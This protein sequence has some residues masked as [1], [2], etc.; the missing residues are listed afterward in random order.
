MNALTQYIDLY[1]DNAEAIMKNS[2]LFSESRRKQACDFLSG[3]QMP[4]KGDEGFEKTSVEDMFAPDFGVNINRVNI[5]VDVAA[6][7]KC[8][9]PNIS[10]LLGIVV[11]DMFVPTAT[12]LKNCPQGV[13]VMS[14]AKAA[15]EFSEIVSKYLGSVAPQDNVNAEL[16]TML[17]QDGVFIRLEAG[18]KL[19]KPIQ[20]VNIFNSPARMLSFRRVLIVAE[21]NSSANILFCDHTQVP[22]IDYLSSEVIEVIAGKDTNLRICNIEESTINTSRYTQ[23]F[24]N[25]ED[26]SNVYLNATTLQNGKSRNDFTI[27][28]NGEHCETFLTG[29][30]IADFDGIVDNNSNVNHNAPRS[31]SNQLFK[32][33][34]DGKAQ[35][36]FEGGI[37][38]SGNAPFTEGYQSNSNILASATAKMHTK[39]QLLI[40]NDEVKCSHG[41]STGQLDENALFYMQQRGIPRSEART[42]LMQAFMSEV[43]DTIPVEGIKDRMRHLVEKRLAGDSMLCGE[44]NS[45]CHK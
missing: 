8:D 14:L 24:V 22:G 19:E 37:Y 16:N 21:E 12:L 42:L 26:G 43:I 10:T 5:P 23:T 15:K 44:C 13:A 35:G 31:H 28:I 38:V 45:E 30:A 39:P 7:F 6:T 27:N 3:K 34:V 33:L 32:Y 40:Y 9:V 18:V 17:T 36:S 20:I 1:R 29:I 4:E 2:S 11:N 25:Q 41:A